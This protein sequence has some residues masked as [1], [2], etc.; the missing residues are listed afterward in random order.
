MKR[1]ALFVGVDEYTDPT[2]KPLEFPSEDATALASVFQWQLKFD[3][4]EKMTNP[5][6][7]PEVVDVVKDMT[8]GLGAGDLFLFFFAGHGFRVKENHVLV[9]AQDEFID[10]EDEEAGLSVGR[11][12]KRMRGPW[13][14]MIV[15]DA[16]QNDIRA[17]R[18]EDGCVASRDL[19]IIHAV[20]KHDSSS[21]LRIVVT[22][23]SEGQ[24]ALEVADLKHGVFTSAFLE[25]VTSLAQ[26]KRCINIET[27]RTDLGVR[28]SG[29]IEKY[30]L[31][32]KQVPMFTMPADAGGVVLL[33][34][35]DTVAP[36]PT[37]SHAAAGAASSKFRGGL[38]PPVA[39]PTGMPFGAQ[40]TF[41]EMMWV[42]V[43]SPVKIS[44]RA[45]RD[46][47]SDVAV[48][49]LNG[50]EELYH[51]SHGSRPFDAEIKFLFN[52]RPRMPG[53][54]IELTVR[55]VCNRDGS[56]EPDVFEATFPIC[57]YEKQPHHSNVDD[58][59]VGDEGAV[60]NH[61]ADAI[62]NV[63][64]PLEASL[65]AT[66]SRLTLE[67][68]GIFIHLWALR[69]EETIICGRDSDCDYMMRV[70]DRMT[71]VCDADKSMC[72]SGRH[73]R[74]V[75]EGGR[76]LCVADGVDSPSTFG[77]SIG[78]MDVGQDGMALGD[79]EYVIDVGTK[80]TRRGV[81]SL[82]VSVTR[83]DDDGSLAGFTITR[84][85]G[86]NERVVAIVS[87]IVSLDGNAFAWDG[88]K[89]L[90]DGKRIVPGVSMD[91]AGVPYAVGTF[92]QK[93]R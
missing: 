30:Q 3:R 69:P 43:S 16:C 86:L 65:V 83:N 35:A 60:P 89:F 23:C 61:R 63:T 41:A 6:H 25:S 27:L 17:T 13:N 73:F 5:A 68:E 51:H 50:D 52:V 54:F 70:F 59:T 12:K 37:S 8:R 88:K 15:L 7:A 20:D 55:F 77:T 1:H 39:V 42:G 19:A 45:A 36:P 46:I 67:G 44:F 93:K 10:L 2:I 31:L 21:G 24:K 62:Q 82:D 26:D 92:H 71:G 84:G 91:V 57:V 75:L 66:P 28:M 18:G 85:D 11:L 32:D 87:R 72:I 22:S 48:S 38:P 76:T 74:F 40:V 79:G 58:S 78:E 4:V 47:Y 56:S 49:V 90:V 9:C 33:D 80:Y 81:F 29:L 34:G 14:Q 64:L 53:S